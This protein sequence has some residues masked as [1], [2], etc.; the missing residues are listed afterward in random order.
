MAATNLTSEIDGIT[1]RYH[2]NGG[3]AVI[4]SI[5]GTEAG[6]G[7]DTT[8]TDMTNVKELIIP[9]SITKDGVDYAVKAIK[10]KAFEGFSALETVEIPTTIDA[11]GTDCFKST[12]LT[13]VL[14]PTHTIS[15]VEY[16][17]PAS[18]TSFFGS[19]P[20]DIST[21]RLI[22]DGNY[23]LELIGDYIGSLSDVLSKMP[24][25]Y[26]P[27]DKTLEIYSRG[28]G[29][30][31]ER[32][33]W[34]DFQFNQG[35]ASEGGKPV[36]LTLAFIELYT[37]QI[38][39]YCVYTKETLTYMESV[40]IDGYS[41]GNSRWTNEKAGGAMR[42]QSAVYAADSTD[43]DLLNVTVKN[44]CRGFRIQDTKNI[45][46]KNCKAVKAP[47]ADYSVSDNAFYFASGSYTSTAGCENCTFEGCVATDVGQTG[48]Q[49]IGG[50]GN[51]FKDCSINGS[52]GAGFSC[53]NTNG[54]ITVYRCTFENANTHE[55][56]ETSGWGGGVD[57]FNGAACGMNV[58]ST[59]TNALVKVS[60]CR[61]KSG[62][63]SVYY[64]SGPGQMDRTGGEYNYVSLDNFPNGWGPATGNFIVPSCFPKG[65]PVVTDQGEVAIEKL[66]SNKY[67]IRGK[68]IVAITKA[69]PLQTH[70]ICFEKGSLG[71]N[72]PSVVTTVSKEHRILYQGVMT[73]ARDFVE[74]CKGVYQVPYN[75][76]TLYNVLLKKEGKMMI[77]NMIC[78]T[79]NPSNTI[80]KISTIK[81][82][83]E[84]EN[85]IIQ[86]N[87]RVLNEHSKACRKSRA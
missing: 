11:I 87:K 41:G 51:T 47:G 10:P 7:I 30:D 49:N 44:C 25:T 42:I 43:P 26:D 53:Y 78:E 48:F 29:I 50:D 46:V 17:S 18:Y 59:D 65:T 71:K 27:T 85:A 5:T 6:N 64:I 77:N 75:G 15:S 60:G 62:G 32:F 84:Q 3:N 55:D 40:T 2:I 74:M 34:T 21:I 16:S 56:G 81:D 68:E 38:D 31:R 58:Q 4:G 57:N 83:N 14:M 20:V 33:R 66:A 28:E 69:T 35:V 76:E 45:V 86:L 73:K 72:V 70:L 52:I 36:K 22:N 23:K 1:W 13:R 9:S 82:A 24:G 67:T 37:A 19:G 39:G 54:T 12:G 79:L 8:N 61:F 80:A 63:G